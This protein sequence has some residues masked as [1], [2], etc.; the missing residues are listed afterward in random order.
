LLHK[1]IELNFSPPQAGNF[2][3]LACSLSILPLSFAMIFQSNQLGKKTGFF[4]HILSDLK[5]LVHK[6][7]G[8]SKGNQ[9][10]P[11]NFRACGGKGSLQQFN[12]T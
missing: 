6:S 11:Q 12:S 8:K 10:K 5:K 9:V 7:N 4:T 3:V 1:E 2:G